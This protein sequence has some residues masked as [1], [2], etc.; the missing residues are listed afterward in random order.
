MKVLILKTVK[1]IGAIGQVKEVAEGYARN[2]LF[3]R[4][5]AELA[6]DLNVAKVKQEQQKV[7]K[8]AEQDLVAVEKLAEKLN[9]TEIEIKGR[10]NDAGKFYAAI[11]AV[12]IVSRLKEMGFD[13]KKDQLVLP[14]PIKEA[15]EYNVVV[16]LSHGLESE[17][18]V[19][20]TE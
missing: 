19:I 2:Y 18:T 16:E 8:V 11:T 7:K 1:G 14:E 4:G 13:V 5:L 12:K 17:I 6:S 3:P 20:A 9:G 10:V 15:G